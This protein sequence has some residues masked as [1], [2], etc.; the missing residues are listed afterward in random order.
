MY[1]LSCKWM[2][3]SVYTYYYHV[4]LFL[5]VRRRALLYHHSKR[6]WWLWWQRHTH[7]HIKRITFHVIIIDA[8][9]CYFT[10]LHKNASKRMEISQF[11]EQHFAHNTLYND[12]MTHNRYAVMRA[13]SVV[14][15]KQLCGRGI[16][17]HVL[18][19]QIIW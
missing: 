3:C 11:I 12:A 1:G 19:H 8:V 13:V 7:A 14:Q 15:N 10:Q 9:L 5:C 18:Q 4:V 16:T 6:V 2:H 17:A